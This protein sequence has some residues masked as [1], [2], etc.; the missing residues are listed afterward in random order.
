MKILVLNAGSSSLKYALYETSPEAAASDSDR[1]LGE[2]LVERVTN[3][4]DALKTAFAGLAP[5]LGGQIVTGVGHRVVH[6]GTFPGST[7]IDASVE[8]AIDALSALAP[9]H[10]P[11]SLAAYR[12]AKEHL[13]NAIHVAVFDTAFHQTLPRHAYAYAMPPEYLTEKKIRRYG[14]HGISHRSVALR[15]AKIQGKPPS[16]FRLV[17]CH[18]GNGCSVCAVDRGLSIDTSMG[19]T[20]LEGLVMGTRSGDVDASALLHLIIREGEDPAALLH[21][22]N[23]ASGLQAV[24]GVSNDMRDVIS[25]SDS[26]ND[27]ARFAVDTFCYRAKKFIGAYLAAMNGA[28]ALIFTAGIG[29]HSAPV[30]AGICDGLDHLGIVVDPA[31]NAAA[32]HEARRIGNSPITVWVIPTEEQLMIARDT[33]GCVVA[34]GGPAGAAGSKAPA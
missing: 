15:F 21:T 31:L 2:G 22:L 16:E 29:E 12:A 11:H 34:A 26:G 17:I 27:R 33:L 7:I 28:D 32:S 23:N 9:L 3:M 20:P 6:G 24:S 25:A 8:S 4:S 18:L 19:F 1:L 30:R 10:N 14:F 13:P 5:A